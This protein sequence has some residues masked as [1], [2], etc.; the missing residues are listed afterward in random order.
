MVAN[1]PQ[2]CILCK[3]CT[4]VCDEWMGEEAIEAGN[5]G[6]NTVIGTFGGTD[7]FADG[8]NEDGEATGFASD[9]GGTFYAYRWRH[10]H[11]EKLAPLPGH[12]RSFGNWINDEGEVCGWSSVPGVSTSAI[13]SSAM[14]ST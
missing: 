8:I 6:A 5:R 12:A 7:S 9:A 13:S 4:R 3:R 2:R 11:V 14:P 10:G 1:D